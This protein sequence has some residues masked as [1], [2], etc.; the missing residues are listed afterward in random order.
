MI[1][2]LL[3]AQP[4]PKKPPLLHL[5][6]SPFLTYLASPHLALP[7]RRIVLGQA[8]QPG[9]TPSEYSG[10]TA[11]DNTAHGTPASFSPC[12][13][14]RRES[15][16]PI[17]LSAILPRLSRV[18]LRLVMSVSRCI[19]SERLFPTASHPR[20]RRFDSRTQRLSRHTLSPG[21]PSAA[22]HYPTGCRPLSGIFFGYKRAN[23]AKRDLVPTSFPSHL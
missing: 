2:E 7:S 12:L 10:T 15:H 17:R 16:G 1:Y 11:V 20:H 5:A 14:S 9:N 8:A 3:D 4:P 22:S 18:F 21:Y 19:A 23:S 6:S 13:W